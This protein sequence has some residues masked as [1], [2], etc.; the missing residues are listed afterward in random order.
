MN[1][2]TLAF[3]AL[4]V[5]SIGSVV[6]VAQKT[7][8]E[9]IILQPTDTGQQMNAVGQAAR[10]QLLGTPLF[11]VRVRVDVPDGTEFMVV[12]N[13]G[14]QDIEMGTIIMKGGRGRLV[15]ELEPNSPLQT[16]SIEVKVVEPLPE[17]ALD[18]LDGAF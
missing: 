7:S 18:I 16:G 11:G 5:V 13:D 2:I 14:E 15:V 3:L 10:G 8:I 17:E 12:V 4:V 1:K 6:A 9:Q